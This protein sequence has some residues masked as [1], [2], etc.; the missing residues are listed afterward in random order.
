M[1]SS[2]AV[3]KKGFPIPLP[4]LPMYIWTVLFVVI[5]LIYILAMSFMR[6]SATWG[7]ELAFTLDSY[8]GIFSPTYLK[9]FAQSIYVALITTV[10][11]L[12]IGYPFAYITAK[13][14]KKVRSIVLMLIVVPFWTNSL[15]RIY[16]W[17]ILLRSKGVI[18]G[19][20]ISLGIIESPLKL[21]Y[22]FSAVMVGMIYALIPFM[23]LSIYNSCEKIDWSLVEAS[24]DLG[25]GKIRA[26][27]TVT[28]PLTMP[29]IM[30]GCVLVF[31]PSVGL[32]FISDLLGGAKTM[33]LGNL[34]KNE[35]L[36]A[37][38]WPMGAALSIIMM[39][40]TLVVISIYKKTAGDKSLEGLL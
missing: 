16:G 27:C 31:I 25:A 10:S 19:L 35:L 11:T 18:N 17:M 13:L 12:L 34:I 37:R 32:F 4:A 20:L 36:V 7:V 2:T 26:F 5:P 9:V 33:L 23:I 29:G 1:K 28:L 24:R 39:L 6:R 14:P 38:N 40:M 21:L 15:V 8:K 22:T 3:K 30:A